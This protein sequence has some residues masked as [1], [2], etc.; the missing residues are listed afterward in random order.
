MTRQQSRMIQALASG[1]TGGTTATA[2][3]VNP[4]AAGTATTTTQQPVVFAMAPARLSVS[5][6]D[7][8][9]KA[10]KV[11]QGDSF[12]KPQGGQLRLLP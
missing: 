9:T 8:S 4:T 12:A 10:G 11:L 7:Y 6:L 1:A 5:I 3:Q 2:A